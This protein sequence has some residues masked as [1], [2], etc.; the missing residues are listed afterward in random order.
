M[1]YLDLGDVLLF[2]V[3]IVLWGSGSGVGLVL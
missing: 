1:A 2:V 3:A